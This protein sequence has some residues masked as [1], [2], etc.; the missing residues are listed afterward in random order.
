MRLLTRTDILKVDE[1]RVLLATRALIRPAK[2]PEP[3]N[4]YKLGSNF[5]CAVSLRAPT[6]SRSHTPP[7]GGA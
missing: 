5:S 7:K 2:Q 3:D 1:A 6:W 4:P